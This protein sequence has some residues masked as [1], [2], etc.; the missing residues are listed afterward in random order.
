MKVT[1]VSISATRFYSLGT[2]GR[3]PV[4]VL[5]LPMVVGTR[6]SHIMSQEQQRQPYLLPR[7]ET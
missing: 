6:W 2:V 3:V 7:G 4:A 5:T 1:G